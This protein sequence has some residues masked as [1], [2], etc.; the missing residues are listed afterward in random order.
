MEHGFSLTDSMEILDEKINHEGFAMIRERLALGDNVSEFFP[1]FAPKIYRGYFEGFIRYMP[2]TD[3]LASSIAL[4]KNEEKNR[5]EIIKG[6]LYPTLLMIGMTCG[7]YLFNAFILPNMIQLLEGFNMDTAGYD[8]LQKVI[9]IASMLMMVVIVLAI[10]IVCFSLQKKQIVN[11]Y[12]LISKRFPDSILVQYA[13]SQF[14]RFYLECEKRN[15]STI[16]TMKILMQVKEKPLVSYIAM[17]MDAHLSNGE[18]LQEAIQFSHVEAALLRF[19]RIAFYA[20][21]CEKMLEG[22]LDMVHFRTQRLIKRF[23]R[24]I[25]LISYSAVGVVLIFVYQI[26]MMPMSMLQNI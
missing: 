9:Q 22:Y 1:S 24:N 6:M 26:L 18:S 2:F 25:Q 11:T 10:C 20:S 7:I 13:S 8:L 14:A 19:F 23:S 17:E 3:A 5:E 16:A 4:V 15:V 21:D 12:R